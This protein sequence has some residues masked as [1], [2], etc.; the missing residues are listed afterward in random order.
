[1]IKPNKEDTLRM[2]AGALGLLLVFLLVYHFY[3]RQNPAE[4]LA[5]KATRV[6]LVSRMRIALAS[7]VEAEKSAVLAVTSQGSQTFANQARAATA[8]VERERVELEELL[9]TGGTQAE[10]DLLKQFSEFFAEYQRIDD[11]LL[12]L[13]V[14]STNIK[15][16]D[17]AFGPAAKAI[18]EMNAA[19]SRILALTA[20]SPEERRVVRLASA[21]EIAG[22]HLLTLIPPHIAEESDKKMDE[23]E[24][25]MARDDEQIRK[26]LAEFAALPPLSR[27]ADLAIASSSYAQFT[28]LKAQILA[29]SRENTNVRSLSLSLNRKRKVTLLCQGSLDELQQAILAEPI[30]GVTYG[31]PARPR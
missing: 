1:M 22:L 31:R 17:M 29:L 2:A 9:R 5:L 28:Q 26:N 6:D 19:L 3:Q 15:A 18:E 20:G 7:A 21:I 12:H 8:E 16:Y 10:K 13:A 14:K 23:L 11:E 27:S 25:S 4:Q 24:A 30:P